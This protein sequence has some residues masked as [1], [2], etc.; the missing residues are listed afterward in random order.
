MPSTAHALVQHGIS[1]FRCVRRRSLACP[2][3]QG[4]PST[5][6]H[7]ATISQGSV[8]SSLSDLCRE[9]TILIDVGHCC[10]GPPARKSASASAA[11][12]WPHEPRDG[13]VLRS[14]WGR[15]ERLGP[16]RPGLEVPV[17]KEARPESRH[18]STPDAPH[19]APQASPLI[20]EA[21]TA[22]LPAQR[23]DGAPRV[24]ICSQD[25]S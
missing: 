3:C 24:R 9:D 5:R 14:G 23:R 16:N 22:R 18:L 11:A 13:P 12:C 17:Q 1:S 25:S 6:S 19:A 4:P 2:H 10:S 21:L 20:T 8:A 15:L 7:V